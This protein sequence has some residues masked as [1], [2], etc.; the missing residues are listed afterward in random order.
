[1]ALD[2]EGEYSLDMA[3]N[4]KNTAG[5]TQTAQASQTKTTRA[6][7]NP[8]DL[9]KT[10]VG[11]VENRVAQTSNQ[12]ESSVQRLSQ[13][14]SET[15]KQL[16]LKAPQLPPGS[17][18]SPA[19]GEEHQQRREALGKAQEKTLSGAVFNANE[20]V[21][22]VFQASRGKIGTDE[23]ALRELMWDRTPEQLEAM[24]QTYGDRYP[25]RN[26][27]DDLNKELED[28]RDRQMLASF[29]EGD[30]VGAATAALLDA[31]TGQTS[32]QRVQDVLERLTPE[33]VAKVQKRYK[34]EHPKG[35][36]LKDWTDSRFKKERGEQI[37]SLLKGDSASAQVAE[38]QRHLRKKNGDQI[39]AELRGLKPEER[40]AFVER[41]NAGA[42]EGEKL[43]DLI[44][45]RLKGTDR[46]QALAL[47]QGNEARADAALVRDALDGWGSNKSKLWDG[48]GADIEDPEQRKAYQQKV[49]SEYNTLYGPQSKK[50]GEALQDRLKSELGGENEDKALTMLEQGEVPPAQQIVYAVSGSRK[51]GEELAGLI[52]KYGAD[53]ARAMYAEATKS[54]KF[55]EGRDLDQDVQKRLG[56]RGRYEAKD[57][58]AGPPQTAEEKVARAVDRTRFET[59]GLGGAFTK[60][61]DI[62]IQNT[63]RAEQALENLK[64]A[65]AN[66]DQAAI[67]EWTLRVDELTGY[68]SEDTKVFRAEKDGAVEVTAGVAAG[69]AAAGAVAL[70]GGAAAPLLVAVA[71]GSSAGAVTNYGIRNIM[72]GNAYDQNN[73]GKDLLVG[74]A[75][76][77]G[78][79]GGAIIGRAVRK[80]VESRVRNTAAKRILGNT[81]EGASDGA[82]GGSF[83]GVADTA[84]QAETWE[85]G[86]P[87]GLGKLKEGG[88][89]GG[90]LG[91]AFGSGMAGGAEALKSVGGR[92]MRSVGNDVAPSKAPETSRSVAKELETSMGLSQSLDSAAIDSLPSDKGVFGW[93]KGLRQRK[94]EPIPTLSWIR[95]GYREAPQYKRLGSEQRKQFEALIETARNDKFDTVDRARRYKAANGLVDML[96][97]GRLL[98][99]DQDGV[100]LL[101]RLDALRKNPRK[102][103]L[104]EDHS[105]I[106]ASAVRM[107]AD[108]HVV[109]QAQRGTCGAVALQFLH[110]K[111]QPADFVRF[112]DELTSQGKATW[113]DGSEATVPEGAF[114]NLGRDEATGLPREYPEGWDVVQ[115]NRGALS[116]VYQSTIIQNVAEHAPHM[117]GFKPE[118]DPLMLKH[119]FKD[120]RGQDA[121]IE[122]T[123]KNMSNLTPDELK[124][125]EKRRGGFRWKTMNGNYVGHHQAPFEGNVVTDGTIDKGQRAVL[126]SM[127]GAE[128]EGYN[129][130]AKLRAA[131]KTKPVQDLTSADYTDEDAAGL[132]TLISG[133]IEAGKT[134]RPMTLSTKWASDGD[135]GYHSVNIVGMTTDGRFIIK[136]SQTHGGDNLK[137]GLQRH[138]N[139][140]QGQP[141]TE[142]ELY[143]LVTENHSKGL[144]AV[145]PEELLANITGFSAVKTGG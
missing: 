66:G 133:A 48:L 1:M 95:H 127:F 78:V 52:R 94:D 131:L 55:P 125:A 44:S 67:D 139:F 72:A 68:A 138:P 37:D 117:P 123:S 30:R 129:V 11:N 50:R 49:E 86:I 108:P 24:A 135:H 43:E 97:D 140:P 51:D 4:I 21:T 100:S 91:T 36:E 17:K 33:E 111:H 99:K 128:V 57:A 106:V 142:N 64:K 41:Y 38:M 74:A 101:E 58:L 31:T 28:P 89:T 79:K 105:A 104:Q 113:R 62:L 39:V 103:E 42:A 92:V 65:R 9:I 143:Q 102:A 116:R 118:Y 2:G 61:D 119:K 69:V 5:N 109:H 59:A 53:E 12:V 56:G 85:N 63:K 110:A 90:V 6:V 134:G 8:F 88:L 45:G 15:T 120:A 23:K 122:I 115:T 7:S 35:R 32:K 83:M 29:R 60:T 96:S 114:K 54:E 46:E 10:V 112:V 82:F 84:L 136:N 34:D 77:V 132:K 13:S 47:V 3:G 75:E 144:S 27:W 70:S 121:E 145:A 40:A 126:K 16:E 25:G 107:V 80:G 98:V 19:P 93:L 141:L 87:E 137:S 26:M 20:D 18:A 73:A 71:A 22:S 14:L 76:G 124:A 81:L 130:S